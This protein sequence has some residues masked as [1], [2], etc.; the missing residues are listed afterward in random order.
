MIYT[1]LRSIEAK[2]CILSL[3]ACPTFLFFSIETGSWCKNTSGSTLV[4]ENEIISK[5]FLTKQVVNIL[6]ILI[7]LVNTHYRQSH[8]HSNKRVFMYNMYFM[9]L[10]I[11]QNIL[12]HF[13]WKNTQDLTVIYSSKIVGE[14]LNMSTT[15]IQSVYL[16]LIFN[17]RV[18]WLEK[19]FFWNYIPMHT[20]FKWE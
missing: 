19:Y 5:V 12:L 20:P 16:C 2:H 13:G 7:Q 4:H 18:I 15:K 8:P 9:F 3:L 1:L 10:C 14:H 6:F 11:I 17:A